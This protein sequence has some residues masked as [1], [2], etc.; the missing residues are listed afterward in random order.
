M[1]SSRRGPASPDKPPQA[2]SS[3][4]EVRVPC[5]PI[6]PGLEAPPGSW[7]TLLSL[8]E[9]AKSPRGEARLPAAPVTGPHDGAF[10]R[11]RP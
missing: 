6:G 9:G 4:R 3:V 11:R 7:V 8:E 1:S 10:W 2:L 5:G